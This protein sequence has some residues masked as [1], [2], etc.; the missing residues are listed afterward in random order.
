M[1]VLI[2]ET[3]PYKIEV[4]FDEIEN[5]NYIVSLQVVASSQAK[6]E[7]QAFR[8]INSTKWLHDIKGS[9]IVDSTVNHS[10]KENLSIEQSYEV[11][12][13]VV[14]GVVHGGKS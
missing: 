5:R 2:E 11:L 9:K 3:R 6:A 10:T 7:E 8:L 13:K 1:T 14:S 4:K 12:P